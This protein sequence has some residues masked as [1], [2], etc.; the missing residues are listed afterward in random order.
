MKVKREKQ[1]VYSLHDMLRGQCRADAL[2]SDQHGTSEGCLPV[3]SRAM[4]ISA[5]QCQGRQMRKEMLQLQV[6]GKGS[7][8]FLG[9]GMSH[10]R[11]PRQSLELLR[12]STNPRTAD[13]NN[14]YHQH[15]VCR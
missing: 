3:T 14:D 8:T 5:D 12:N 11:L 10:I 15:H 1:T 4:D 2:Y 9:F 7:V 6:E 13:V